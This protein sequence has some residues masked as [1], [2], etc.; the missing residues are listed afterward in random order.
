MA[1]RP[2]SN[3]LPRERRAALAEIRDQARGW[4][5][6]SKVNDAEAERIVRLKFLADK[7][8]LTEAQARYAEIAYRQLRSRRGW[9]A[10]PEPFPSDLRQLDLN[11][12]KAEVE[13]DYAEN[14]EKYAVKLV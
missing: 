3:P 6:R 2:R 11:T 9:S 7:G 5:R 1:G 4:G 12:L 14:P 13:A 8:L 10:F